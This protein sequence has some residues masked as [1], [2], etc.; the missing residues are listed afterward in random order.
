MEQAALNWIKSNVDGFEGDNLS[1]QYKYKIIGS[2]IPFMISKLLF[3]GS[4]NTELKIRVLP[5]SS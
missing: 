3:N 2:H 1:I 5:G 4:K